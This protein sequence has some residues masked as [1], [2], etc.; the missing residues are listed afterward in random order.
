MSDR[1]AVRPDSVTD[2]EA[3]DLLDFEDDLSVMRPPNRAITMRPPNR[4]TT[5]RPPNRTM[6]MRPPNRSR[7]FES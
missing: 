7:T 5:M 4:T 6:T 1:L 3:L 2:L